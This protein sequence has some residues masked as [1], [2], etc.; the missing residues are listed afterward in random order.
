MRVGAKE[1]FTATAERYELYR[2]SYPAT[3]IDWLLTTA[4]LRPGCRVADLGCGTGISTRLLSERALDVV[5]IDPNEGM[6]ERARARGGKA[7]YAHGESTDSGLPSASVDL[8][9]AA[10]AFHWF[11]VPATMRELDRILKPSGWAAAFWNERAHTPAMVDYEQLLL[12]F[13]AEY[14]ALPRLETT[15]VA[16][17]ATP[18]LAAL[19]P[20]EFANGQSLDWDA[21]VGRVY[22]S[23]YV[24][25]GVDRKAEFDRELFALFHRHAHAGRFEFAYRVVALAWRLS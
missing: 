20:A 24:V 15:R 2:P 21:F 16:I 9:T 1:R 19:V 5:G 12:A 6:L 11:D 8:V 23:S 17:C 10:Q 13:S 3:L 7:T 18:H 25:H 14:A 4:S 22:S